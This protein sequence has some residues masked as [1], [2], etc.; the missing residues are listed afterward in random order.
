VRK[1]L[2]IAAALLVLTTVA[3]WT[4][5][6]D[7]ASVAPQLVE[8]EPTP[9]NPQSA[10]APEVPATVAAAAPVTAP[11]ALDDGAAALEQA[12][13][14]RIN[15]RLGPGF[16]DYLAKQGLARADA[17]SIVALLAREMAGCSFDGMRAQAN[18]QRVAFDDVLNALEAQLYDTD[19]PPLTALLDMQAVAQREAPCS[20]AALQR[21]G[22]SPEAATTLV[23]E[24]LNARGPRRTSP[25]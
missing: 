19:G 20:L 24:A 25:R 14:E 13:A 12:M 2:V 8:R 6:D 22:V 1:T 23:Q 10:P 7:A 21:S 17:E 4:R 11:P 5:R 16:V 18:E 9:T 3:L 15:A